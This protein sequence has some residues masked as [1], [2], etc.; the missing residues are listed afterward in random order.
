M[1]DFLTLNREVSGSNMSDLYKL[2]CLYDK[3]TLWSCINCDL[4]LVLDQ[5][6]F[7]ISEVELKF[8]RLHWSLEYS[9]QYHGETEGSEVMEKLSDQR[10]YRQ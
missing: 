4:V 8:L 2:S 9:T 10:L 6:F 7:K 5:Q 3:L 1:L